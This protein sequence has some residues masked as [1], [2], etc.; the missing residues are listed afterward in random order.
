MLLSLNIVRCPFSLYLL[1]FINKW[2]PGL[3]L[4]YDYLFYIAIQTMINPVIFNPVA[5]APEMDVALESADMC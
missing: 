5:L 1:T 2:I 3:T 4:G